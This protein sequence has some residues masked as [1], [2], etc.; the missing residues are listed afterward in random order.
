MHLLLDE[1]VPRP[2]KRDIVGHV[3]EHVTDRGWAGK[4]NGE[5]LALMVREGFAG[6]VTVDQNLEF[7]QN[8]QASGIAVI[9][10]VAQ[11]NRLK[12]LRPLVPALLQAL[13]RF[14][15]GDL[16][17]VGAQP[18]PKGQARGVPGRGGHAKGTK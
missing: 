12:E 3:V 10:L 6:L 9:V 14:A 16:I 1:C 8:V 5:L 18:K 4:E 7:Q 13:E 11:A 15:P 2:L 17:R